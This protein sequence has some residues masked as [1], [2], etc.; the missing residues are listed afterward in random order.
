MSNDAFRPITVQDHK[1]LSRIHAEKKINA[2]NDALG[3]PDGDQFEADL[4]ADEG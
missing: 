4:R 1:E 3:F 2:V